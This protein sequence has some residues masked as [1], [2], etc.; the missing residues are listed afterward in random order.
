MTK[1]RKLAVL[2][3]KQIVDILKSEKD[4][5]ANFFI[6]AFKRKFCEK[7]DLHWA[8]DCWLCN[9]V[10]RSDNFSDGCEKCPLKTCIGTES[11]YGRAYDGDVSAAEEILAVLE[12]KRG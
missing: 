8:L 5:N 12:G 9:Y 10:N 7:H 1:E 3:W 2:M 11:L 6:P 4:V